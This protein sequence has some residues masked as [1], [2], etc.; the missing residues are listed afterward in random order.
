[1]KKFAL[2]KL[3]SSV[4]ITLQMADGRLSSPTRILTKSVLKALDYIFKH[5]LLLGHF[6]WLA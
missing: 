6:N 3:S 5:I 1:M 2:T 4:A